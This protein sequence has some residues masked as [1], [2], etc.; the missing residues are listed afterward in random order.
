M[1]TM[2]ATPVCTLLLCFIL[3]IFHSVRATPFALSEEWHSL[4]NAGS[5]ITP[6]PSPIPQNSSTD[7]NIFRTDPREGE[8]V[9][10]RNWVSRYHNYGTIGRRVSESDL[11]TATN[12]VVDQ[13]QQLVMEQGATTP[14]PSNEWSIEIT[15]GHWTVQYHVRGFEHSQMTMSQLVIGLRLLQRFITFWS[16]SG[17][18]P[19]F[20]FGFKRR[21]A[22]RDMCSG[23]MSIRR[24]L[25][26]RKSTLSAS[27]PD[28]SLVL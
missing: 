19:S 11:Y 21:D 8:I 23:E 22:S 16:S 9:Y 17:S 1:C 2:L 15:A 10:S 27:P 3:V 25:R 5:P 6:S 20:S 7:E 24:Q 26:P 14:V 28:G 12:E 18:V 13:L 4:M